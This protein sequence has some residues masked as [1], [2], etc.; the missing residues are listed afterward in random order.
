MRCH[1]TAAVNFLDW[2]AGSGSALAT[3]TQTDVDRWIANPVASYR[4]ETGHFIRWSVQHRHT[5]GLTYRTIRWTGPRGTLDS[6]KHWADARRLLHDDALST[7]DRVAGLLLVL[8][9]QRIATISQLTIDHVHL[10]TDTVKIIYQALHRCAT[11]AH[12]G[13]GILRRT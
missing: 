3:C 1:V 6:E 4:D 5:T 10:S 2:M 12:R 9:A 13:D 8:Y 7:P 11:R